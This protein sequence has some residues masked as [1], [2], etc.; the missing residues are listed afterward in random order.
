MKPP[1]RSWSPLSLLWL[2]G[3]SNAVITILLFGLAIYEWHSPRH[4]IPSFVTL[5]A[6]AL[7]VLGTAT[8]LIAESSLRNGV[9]SKSW[10]DLQLLVPRRL[11]SHP[12]LWVWIGS[13]FAFMMLYG[14]FSW[15][16]SALGTLA[17]PTELSLIRVSTIL[18]KAQQNEE[19][20]SSLHHC[21]IKPLHSENWGR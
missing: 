7:I 9:E 2:V 1:L 15:K 10:S 5:N 12:A 13:L 16:N 21:S 4:S 6:I 17:F 18:Q 8:S 14:I 19:D 11:A 3:I 20:P